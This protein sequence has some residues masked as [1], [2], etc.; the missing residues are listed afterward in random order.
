MG[1][2]EILAVHVE[3]AEA[4][5]R[6]DL[7]R[8]G[9]FLHDDIEV[10]QLGGVLVEGLDAYLSMMET[11]YAG[12]ADFHTV[13]DDRFAT[14]DR[15]VCRWR[16][17]GVHASDDLFQVPATGRHIEFPGISLWEFEGAKARR[18]WTFSDLA[19]IMAQV[20]AP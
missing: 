19:T 5:N 7:S 8:H 11:L 3:W 16:S 12:M 6:H 20:L 10:H 2:A 9:E 13:I 18:G 1:A 17:S 4:E 14:D 15:V